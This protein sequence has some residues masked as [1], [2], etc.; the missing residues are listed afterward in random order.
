MPPVLQKPD[1]V[2]SIKEDCVTNNGHRWTNEELKK[3]M[4][5]WQA[6]LSIKDISAALSVSGFAAHKMIVKLRQQGI[7]LLRRNKGHIA[8]RKNKPWTQAEVEYLMRRRKDKAT[9]EDIAIEL[10]RSFLG[11]QGMIQKLRSEAVP[12]A[13]FGQ[14]KRRLWNADTLRGW[15]LEDIAKVFA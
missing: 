15:V 2:D 10:D 6:G 7:P 11:V 8:G 14:G 5:M 13:R 12:V 3:L 4:D 1:G 9:A